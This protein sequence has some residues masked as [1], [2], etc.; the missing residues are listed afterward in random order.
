MNPTNVGLLNGKYTVESIPDSIKDS[1]GEWSVYSRNFL[2]EIDRKLIKDTLVFDTISEYSFRLEMKNS[3]SIQ[4]EYL[5]DNAVFRSRTL[6][7]KITKDGYLKLKNKNLQLLLLPYVL[8][9]IDVKRVRL[10][11]HEDGNLIFD[12]S[13]HRSGAALLMVFLDGRNFQHTDTFRRISDTTK[14]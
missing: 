13:E 1:N 12:V 8:G 7:A 4:I 5:K 9:G 6:K 2:N 11:I 14:L 3:K 10:T